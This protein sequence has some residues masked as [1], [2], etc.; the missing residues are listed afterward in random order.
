MPY[1]RSAADC[2]CSSGS[3]A[4]SEFCFT[5]A[6]VGARI[7]L[8]TDFVSKPT[9]AM[10]DHAS[11][12]ASSDA[13]FHP[14]EDPV[15]A[16]L[17]TCSASLLGK[18]SGSF[19]I[20]CTTAN[21]LALQHHLQSCDI[22]IVGESSHLARHEAF[23]MQ[24]LLDDRR[25]RIVDSPLAAA[26]LIA[27]HRGRVLLWLENT[28]LYEAGKPLGFG[29]LGMLEAV[30][31]RFGEELRVH[32]D[33]S[34]IFNAHAAM[35]YRLAS[36]FRST[37]SISF[38]LNKGLCAPTGAMLVGSST[39]IEEANNR[40]ILEAR[41]IRPA[42][43]AAAYGMVAIREM[44]PVLGDDNRRA[45]AAAA[46]LRRGSELSGSYGVE[47]GG[48]NIVFI[49]FPSAELSTAFAADLEARHVMVRRFRDSQTIR[50]VFHKDVDDTAMA[51]LEPLL[52]E[53]L[54]R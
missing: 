18:E 3:D 49:T 7:D 35:N 10:I 28:I 31:E 53:C 9:K 45:A 4:L 46:L 42:H 47:Y 13:T 38:S 24:G 11:Q 12:I 50:L 34:R 19:Q 22:A 2:P 32:I 29:E 30:R 36:D 8:R 52:V 21:Y 14:W 37:D 48:T 40:S 15:V 1:N 54:L 43:I 25:I 20:N 41:I 51:R 16:E 17:A 27:E 44:L 6:S 5:K 23:L 39:L 26:P 33:G